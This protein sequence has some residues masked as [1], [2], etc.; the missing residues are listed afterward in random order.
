LP[1]AASLSAAPPASSP[2]GLSLVFL[3][4]SPSQLNR[5]ALYR[6]TGLQEGFVLNNTG[7][8]GFLA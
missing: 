6:E 3:A 7:G 4:S 1:S 2:R 8:I 5:A